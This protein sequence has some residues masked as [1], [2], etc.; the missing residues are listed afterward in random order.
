[1]TYISCRIERVT[2]QL[3]RGK[4]KDIE[5]ILRSNEKHY[6]FS[7]VDIQKLIWCV[8]K[9]LDP[10]SAIE[11]A[12]RINKGISEINTNDNIELLEIKGLQK[13]V[14]LAVKN[15]ETIST[16]AKK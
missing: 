5:I 10:L 1:M 14:T 3:S 6:K 9:D 12:D 4:T 8:N 11:Y 13:N 2:V 15:E 7:D 16:G